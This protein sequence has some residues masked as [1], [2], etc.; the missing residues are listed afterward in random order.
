MHEHARYDSYRY[1]SIKKD[2]N[3]KYCEDLQ[4]GGPRKMDSELINYL[5]FK[6]KHEYD[7]DPYSI[8]NYCGIFRF[9]PKGKL[10]LT[11]IKK[12]Q[13]KYGPRADSLMM[14]KEKPFTGFYKSSVNFTYYQYGKLEN[15]GDNIAFKSN[16]MKLQSTLI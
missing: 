15:S 16:L 4:A 5:E 6:T 2:K 13:K 14:F 8:M 7:Y 1:G 11:D 10:S 12:V 9:P 3:K